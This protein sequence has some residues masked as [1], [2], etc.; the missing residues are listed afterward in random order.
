MNDET[1]AAILALLTVSVAFNLFLTL[2][3]ARIVGSNEHLKSPMTLPIGSTLPT[4]MGRTLGDDRPVLAS[5]FEG[6]AS[7]LL[8]FAPECKDCQAR[9][10]EVSA[11][12]GAM[13]RAG[14]GIWVI[15]S[16]SKRRMRAFLNDT[17]LVNHVLIVRASTQRALNP[18]SSAPFYIF[19]DHNRNVLASNFIGDE[20]WLSFC[21][22]MRSNEPADS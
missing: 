10:A 4:F 8:F 19:V 5:E 14:V 11:M 9:V 18:R 7:V 13:R 12:Y 17:P 15:A 2:R 1:F 22:Q 3:L 6:Q 16:I 21:E 20:D